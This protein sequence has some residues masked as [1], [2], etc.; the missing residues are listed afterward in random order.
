[1]FSNKNVEKLIWFGV[2][3]K[4]KF[5][6]TYIKPNILQ[7]CGNFHLKNPINFLKIEYLILCA[8]IIGPNSLS[9]SL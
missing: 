4:R 2:L 1:M 5:S 8:C 3:D 7:K 9:H 6:H